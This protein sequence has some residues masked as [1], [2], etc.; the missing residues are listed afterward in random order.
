MIAESKK[1]SIQ[2]I[3]RTLTPCLLLF[4]CSCLYVPVKFY[5]SKYIEG[6]RF[7]KNGLEIEHIE[8]RKHYLRKQYL[9]S[10]GGAVQRS[11]EIAESRFLVKKN[12]DEKNLNFLEIEGKRPY[13]NEVVPINESKNWF[14]MIHLENY[15]INN[16][17]K[18]TS[19]ILV[20]VFN[21]E[22]IICK[23]RV[24]NCFI[25]KSL[26][27]ERNS[28]YTVITPYWRQLDIESQE[29]DLNYKIDLPN[30][31]ALF[32]TM[33]GVE[34]FDLSD[35][36]WKTVSPSEYSAEE[37]RAEFLSQKAAFEKREKELHNEIEELFVLA[38]SAKKS[39][40]DGYS[41]DLNGY[42]SK[43]TE[44]L[45]KLQKRISIGDPRIYELY[46]LL[47]LVAFQNGNL[48][49]AK[50]YLEE[51]GCLWCS[52]S[53]IQKDGPDMTLA[54][55]LLHKGERLAVIKYLSHYKDCYHH[56]KRKEWIALI[57][58]GGIP[59]FDRNI[60]VEFEDDC[61]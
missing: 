24:P 36:S 57:E 56:E 10:A 34:R 44:K 59:N 15:H 11:Q 38:N 5:T 14:A 55:V 12:G 47:G 54:N 29:H 31:E 53:S 58:L 7:D 51:L 17:N 49:T 9:I 45:P 1:P 37:Y 39:F 25:K 19:D 52:I 4:L 48:D 13:F 50:M 26:G 21:E 28:N 32:S 60:N 40:D 22:K 33:N 41:E 8:V 27:W 18:F 23:K 16:I 42:V 61:F 2:I 35:C 3:I 43:I 30:N 46:R 6:T 20:V